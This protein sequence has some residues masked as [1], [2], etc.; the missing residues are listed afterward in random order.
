MSYV[1]VYVRLR[2]RGE[3]V[4]LPPPGPYKCRIIYLVPITF[5]YL[6]NLT[7][8]RPDCVPARPCCLVHVLSS[9][10]AAWSRVGP[11]RDIVEPAPATNPQKGGRAQFVLSRL[12]QGQLL[13]RH[14]SR[15]KDR[16]LSQPSES[17][18]LQCTALIVRTSYL[19]SKQV[20]DKSCFNRKT[21]ITIVH[22]QI[23]SKKPVFM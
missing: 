14:L 22:F 5:R 23:M 13:Y 3:T 1:F 10:E 18:G 19:F 12:V 20:S 7:V 17:Y 21:G 11:G 4:G 8:Y 2:G 15:R 6:P 16:N 9:D